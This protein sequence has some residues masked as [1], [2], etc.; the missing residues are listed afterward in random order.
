MAADIF[1]KIGTFKG[2]SNDDKHKEEI[3][4]LSW[5]WGVTNAGS[6]SMG[7]GGGTGK[8]SFSDINFMHHLDKASPNLWKACAKGTH[9]DEATLTQRKAGDGQQ[10]F[11]KIK[12]NDV[13]ITSVQDSGSDGGGLPTESVSLN[14]AKVEWEYFVQDAKGN[15]ASAGKVSYDLKANKAA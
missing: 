4:V 15:M 13:V 11:L 8:A 12:L 1:F 7:G 2:E 10:E 14:F 3:E 5:S 9:I 6:M